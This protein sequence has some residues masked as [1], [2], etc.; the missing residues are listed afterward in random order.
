MP[1]PSYDTFQRVTLQAGV[2][3]CGGMGSVAVTAD[4]TLDEAT[5]LAAQITEAVAIVRRD[6]R[7]PRRAMCPSG[8]HACEFFAGHEGQCYITPDYLRGA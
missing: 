2:S 3:Q 5:A 7:P 1:T 8:P 6:Q 4:V